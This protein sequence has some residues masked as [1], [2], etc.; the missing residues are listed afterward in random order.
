MAAMHKIFASWILIAFIMTGCGGG[1][2]GENGPQPG[3]P[4]TENTKPVASPISLTVD[5]SERNQ[6]ITL[7]GTDADGDT[8]QYQFTGSPTGQGYTSVSLNSSIVVRI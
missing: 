1:E 7:I 3:P 5:T 2:D 6:Q 8:L 4:P